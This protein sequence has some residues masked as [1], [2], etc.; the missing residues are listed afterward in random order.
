MSHN[1]TDGAAPGRRNHLTESGPTS[2]RNYTF[3][4][5]QAAS[6]IVISGVGMLLLLCFLVSCV[7]IILCSGLESLLQS[8]TPTLHVNCIKSPIHYT[9]ILIISF[10]ESVIIALVSII[11]TGAQQEIIIITPAHLQFFTTV[12]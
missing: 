1:R 2:S 3:I 11:F 8:P 12:H 4:P 5:F 6:P 9:F 7:H 10:S